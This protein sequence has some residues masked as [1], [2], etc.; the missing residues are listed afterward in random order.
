MSKAGPHLPITPMFPPLPPRA[1][2]IRVGGIEVVLRL[3][4]CLFFAALTAG[5]DVVCL[6]GFVF[7]PP[8]AA[9]LAVEIAVLP[10]L[11]ATLLL[12]EGGHA[13]ALY[14]QGYRPLRITVHVGGAACDAVI[15]RQLP[16]EALARAVAGPAMTIVATIPLLLVWIALPAMSPWNLIAKPVA[17]FGLLEGAANTLPLYAR[18]DGMAALGAL[19][20]LA[21]GHAPSAFAALYIWRPLALAALLGATLAWGVVIGGIVPGSSLFAGLALG[22][23]ALSVIALAAVAHGALAG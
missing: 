6:P 18:S 20:W 21:R 17:V 19:V 15:T 1:A 23:L 9:H 16:G 11:I 22:M 2:V 5:L 14:R 12:H 13:A 8:T 10:L 3:G 7:G 4:G